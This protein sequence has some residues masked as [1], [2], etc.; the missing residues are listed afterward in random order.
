[1]QAGLGWL[2]RSTRGPASA[3]LRHP[4]GDDHDAAE[5]H[6]Q[7]Q[8]EPVPRPGGRPARLPAEL[9]RRLGLRHAGCAPTGSTNW[10]Y[11]IF[12]VKGYPLDHFAY[13]SD[14]RPADR[15]GLRQRR[16][17]PGQHRPRRS[18]TRPGHIFGC[19]DEYASSG[20]NCGGAWGRF[21]EP[22]SNC[23]NCAGAAGVGCLMRANEWAMCGA[24]EASPRVGAHVAADG[25]A[26]A[27]ATSSAGA[28]TSS[29][30][31]SSDG[32][33][34][35]MT[36]AWEPA[37]VSWWEGWWNLLGGRAAP[38]APVTARVAPARLPRRVRRRHRRRRLHLRLGARRTG[39][40]GWWRIGN[41][42]FPQGAMISAVSRSQ[43]HLDI[44][45][46]D[47]RGRVLTAAWEPAF[48]DG[49]HGWWELNGGRARARRAGHGR[50]AQH[51]QARHVR[52]RHRRRLLHGGVGAGLHRLVA[53]LV[54]DPATRVF[55]QGAY[56]GAVSRSADHLDIFAT[57]TGGRD[58][59]RRVGA[60]VRRRLARLVADP[61]RRGAARRAR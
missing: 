15:H 3:V 25:A 43:D 21:G 33:G 40:R 4:A 58:H 27:R 41:A 38:G 1:M 48:A 6:R 10:A 49:W 39:W 55:P 5:R 30:C 32:G 11:C 26:G 47:S 50:V 53:R 8:R 37:M 17:G 51:E 59:H 16:L 19:P 23:E 29:T 54:A 9:E 31:S 2:G 44:F 60:G 28:R 61:G 22:N 13:A 36:A 34:N 35:T 57:D 45:A 7:R 46:T 42:V 18:P 20:C 52:D 12:F 24:D 56:V 14:R